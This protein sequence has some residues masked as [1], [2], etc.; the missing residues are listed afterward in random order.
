MLLPIKELGRLIA[1]KRGGRGVRAT[2]ADVGISAATLS[3][4]ENGHMPDLETFAKICRWLD[5]DAREFL[6]LG[7]QAEQSP[8]AVVHFRKQKTVAPETAVALGE[9]IL[10]AQRAIQARN[11]LIDP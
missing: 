4:V 7:D 9:L 1:V 10:A 3:R 5:R 2:A 8:Q 11:Q 6:G